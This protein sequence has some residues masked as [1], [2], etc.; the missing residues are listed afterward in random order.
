M[1]YLIILGII[2]VV[3]L[4][5]EKIYHI[6]LYHNRKERCEIVIL[7][8]IMGVIWDSYA[9]WRGHWVYPPTSNTGIFLGLMPIED[10]F[11]VLILPYFIITL[12]KIIDSKYRKARK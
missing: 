4:L 10:Y 9:I 3:T 2:F 12:Y 8:F 6:H 11:F 7:F 5:L 1:E